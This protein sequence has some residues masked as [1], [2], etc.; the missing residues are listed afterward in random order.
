MG[1]PVFFNNSC[2]SCYTR[3]YPFNLINFACNVKHNSSHCAKKPQ[4]CLKGNIN[5]FSQREDFPHSTKYVI[6]AAVTLRRKCR[7]S[8]AP[9]NSGCKSNPL[10]VAGCFVCPPA[11]PINQMNC[12]SIS[13][14]YTQKHRPRPV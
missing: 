12:S 5:V 7:R 10:L 14:M 4:L 9:A 8:Q 3:V 11:E 6:K 13:L 2:P 1:R